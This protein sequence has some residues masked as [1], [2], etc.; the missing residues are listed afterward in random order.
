VRVVAQRSLPL[1]ASTTVPT[2]AFA[3]RRMAV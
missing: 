3:A 1:I 2:S